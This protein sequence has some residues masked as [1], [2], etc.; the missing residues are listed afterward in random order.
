MALQFKDPCHLLN[1][2]LTKDITLVEFD[3]VQDFVAHF[4][5]LLKN[6]RELLRKIYI[7]CHSMNLES[8]CLSTV[9]PSRW[10][11]IYEALAYVSHYW[12]P[13]LS[14]LKS[15][16]AVGQK[17]KRLNVLISTSESLSPCKNFLSK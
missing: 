13:I 9:S 2:T 1:I 14:F 6:L 15:N 5:A 8:K 4:P 16:N 12:R 10:F 3:V 11:S 17:C 7:L